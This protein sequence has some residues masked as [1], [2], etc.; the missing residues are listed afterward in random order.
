MVFYCFVM[1]EGVNGNFYPRANSKCDFYIWRINFLYLAIIISIII[2]LLS[3]STEQW[4]V[5]VLDLCTLILGSLH[6]TTLHRTL[7]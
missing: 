7:T 1:S 4:S 3:T 6:C 5:V 2:L